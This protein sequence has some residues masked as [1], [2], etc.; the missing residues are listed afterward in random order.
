M[1]QGLGYGLYNPTVTY[2]RE[3]PPRMS[4]EFFTHAHNVFIDIW[5]QTGIVGLVLL[6]V[7]I[8]VL[9][10]WF[11]RRVPDSAAA[12][13]GVVLVLAP[14]VRDLTDESWNGANAQLWWLLLGVWAGE[15][16]FKSDKICHRGTP[17]KR[18]CA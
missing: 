12:V 11:W 6:C 8:A 5:L 14:F 15:I 9:L 18:F 13:S 10:Y 2:G 4:P 17:V 3:H 1:W 16:M 7:F